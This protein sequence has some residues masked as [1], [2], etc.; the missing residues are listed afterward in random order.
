M[1]KVAIIIGTSSGLGLATARYLLDRGF[2]V[3]GGSRTESPLQHEKFID[4]EIDITHIN[5]IQ[6]FIKEVASDFEGID[7][8]MNTACVCEMNS[9]TDTD[10]TDLYDHFKTNIE[11]HFNFLK[12]VEELILPG[13]TQFIN[14]L[15][16]SAKS[17][18]ENTLSYTLSESSKLAML[19]TFEKEWKVHD[20]LFNNIFL[21]AIDTPLWDN[22]SDIDRTNMLSISDVLYYLRTII[23]APHHIK[24]HDLTLTHR[25]GFIE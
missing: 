25:S 24:L 14:L 12:A 17:I 13:K 15:S 9:V 22:Y 2:V 8:F 5:Q 23:E 7:L 10:A 4:L 11:A 1:N 6:N 19:K 3:Y 18:Y 21:G 20:V 16:I